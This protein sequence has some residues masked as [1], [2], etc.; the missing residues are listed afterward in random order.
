MIASG[1]PREGRISLGDG[2]STSEL[3]IE[4]VFDLIFPGQPN[5][6]LAV[7]FHAFLDDSSDRDQSKVIVSASFIGTQQQW[8]K[9]R[10][11]WSKRLKE[12]GLAYFKASDYWRLTGEFSKYRSDSKYPRPAGRI[13]AEAVRDDLEKIVK[14][15]GVGGIAMVIPVPVFTEVL[16][17]SEVKEKLGDRPYLWVFQS[18]LFET[19]KEVRTVPG[20]HV[21]TFVHD[22]G[23]DSAQL[24][25]KYI[26]FKHA[27]PKTS[28][29]M[30]GFTSLDDKQHPP[31]QC[32]DMIANATS[33]FAAQWLSRDDATLERLKESVLRVA[34]WD[35]EYMLEVIR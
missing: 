34:V 21:V 12:D 22:E 32:A 4:D 15:S 33:H 2:A 28:R 1:E 18:L 24:L 29:M 6:T 11:A 25:G 35:K 8:S 30:G 9:L 16:A 13:A 17:M 3:K 26:Q 20:Q 31:L 27:N 23:P 7:V 5:G 14:E 19:V 10:V